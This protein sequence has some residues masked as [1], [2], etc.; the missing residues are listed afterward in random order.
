MI[1]ILAFFHIPLH[2]SSKLSYTGGQKRFIEIC[3]RWKRRKVDLTII[4]SS[5]AANLCKKLG[6]EEDFIEYSF[7]KVKKQLIHM[8]LRDFIFI[9]LLRLFPDDNFDLICC[10]SENFS[11][12]VT[13]FMAKTIYRTPV[14]CFLP[15]FD[16]SDK[17]FSSA[18]EYRV[19]LSKGTF[20]GYLNS[21][22]YALKIV[23]RNK[24]FKRFDYFFPVVSPYRKLLT[25]IGVDCKRISR[26]VGAGIYFQHL[27]A[28]DYPNIEKK[29]DA[30]FMASLIERKGIFD[31]LPAWRI[32]CRL[33]PSSQLLIMGEGSNETL[34][35]VK[36]MIDDHGLVDNIILAGFVAGDKKYR[37]LQKSTLF[38]LPSYSEGFAQSIFEA[39][40]CGLPVIAYKNP[41]YE[42]FYKDNLI[43]VCKGDVKGLALAILSLLGDP[44]RLKTLGEKNRLKAVKLSK[45]LNWDYIAQFKLS[46]IQKMLN[47]IKK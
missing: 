46:H 21:F 41:V 12:V 1:R 31:L 38:I 28:H 34:S 36:A 7:P 10:H 33:R 15:L 47:H 37:Y 17:S 9:R 39:M 13:C 23:I 42:Q 11:V 35:K 44:V 26:G 2:A 8:L 3:K 43:Q 30:C 16:E 20:W 32:V 27:H 25:G 24:L 22:F 4:S 29:F 45:N 19:N 18:F 5:Y 14:V 40:A 6:L